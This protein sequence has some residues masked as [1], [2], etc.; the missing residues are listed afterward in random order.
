MR[1]LIPLLV[2]AAV[3][4]VITTTALFASN[5]Q[6]SENGGQQEEEAHAALQVDINNIFAPF[7]RPGFFKL[8]AD[9]TDMKVK[10]GHVAISNVQCDSNGK[11]PF[12]VVIANANVGAGNTKLKIIQ[13]NSS[14]LVDDVSF[15]GSFC[16]Y[17]VDV[18]DG[19]LTDASG[20]VVPITDIALANSS[21]SSVRPHDTASATIH[22]DIVAMEGHEH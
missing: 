8:L 12:V 16:T 18:N 22:A 1:Y 15:K 6:A 13:L 11:S 10:H 14:N 4:G 9:F 3:A 17:H 20:N 21:N 5:V 2:I 19:D 7:G